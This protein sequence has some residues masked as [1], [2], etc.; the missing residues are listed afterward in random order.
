MA[1]EAV[2]GGF[3][4]VRLEKGNRNSRGTCFWL[5]FLE[6]QLVSDMSFQKEGSD[7][8][9]GSGGPGKRKEKQPL[10]NFWSISLLIL[11]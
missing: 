9:G 1:N 6:G 7:F 2:F 10:D 11:I 8:F 5:I 3:Q 4:W